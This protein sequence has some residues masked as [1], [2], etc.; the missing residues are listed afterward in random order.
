MAYFTARPNGRWEIRESHRT[1]RGPRSRTLASF[2]ELSPEVL[3]RA[4]ARSAE[5]IHPDRL[6]R[7]AEAAGVPTGPGEADRLARALLA[8]V[9][10]ERLPREPLRRALMH[11]LRRH[12]PALQSSAAAGEVSREDREADEVTGA[13]LAEVLDL[14]EALPYTPKKDLEYPRLIDRVKRKAA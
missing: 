6:R 7:D 4:V 1:E 11:N 10:Q 12:D 9:A 8:L 5:Q 13:R 14:A 2:R 3:E